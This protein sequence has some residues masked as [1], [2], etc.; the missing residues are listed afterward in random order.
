MNYGAADNKRIIRI[1]QEFFVKLP[2]I[3]ATFSGAY[4]IARHGKG[5]TN[6]VRFSK[7]S[8]KTAIIHRESVLYHT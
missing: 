8:V 6:I 5:L 3:L 4:K 7:M 2:F 1:Y